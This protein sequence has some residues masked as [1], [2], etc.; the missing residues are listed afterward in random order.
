MGHL[1]LGVFG[2]QC[3]RTSRSW[4]RRLCWSSMG[5]ALQLR[6]TSVGPGWFDPAHDRSSDQR[7]LCVHC[8]CS[9]DLL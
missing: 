1:S 5:R 3:G 8:L 7:K 9:V 2:D 6:R 4:L